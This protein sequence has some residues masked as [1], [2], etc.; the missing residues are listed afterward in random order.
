MVQHSLSLADVEP[1]AVLAIDK[2][3]IVDLQRELFKV[4]RE[5]KDVV[6]RLGQEGGVLVDERERVEM[7][8]TKNSTSWDGWHVEDERGLASAEDVREFKLE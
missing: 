7:E 1:V 3:G 5:G 6:L 4:V 2:I 8:K